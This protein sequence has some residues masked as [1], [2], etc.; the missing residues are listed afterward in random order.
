MEDN[1]RDQLH[2][3]CLQLSEG[4]SVRCMNAL[5]SLFK[6]NNERLKPLL[7]GKT[8]AMNIPKCGKK[9]A[10]EVE[11]VMSELRPF[12][13]Q[14]IST[15]IDELLL[16]ENNAAAPTAEST[17]SP[18]ATMYADVDEETDKLIQHL[19]SDMVRKELDVRLRHIVN[20]NIP[21]YRD[22]EQFL[23][24]P[25]LIRTWNGTG[26]HSADAI[27]RF[28]GRF[29]AHFR[30]MLSSD[31]LDLR[32]QMVALD[33]PFLNAEECS[34]AAQY[35][36]DHG[37]Y[38]Q[39]F[40]AHRYFLTTSNKKSRIYAL[41]NGII[42]SHPSLE[43]IARKFGMSRERIRQI[44]LMP[45]TSD[46]NGKN[47]WLP[48]HWQSYDFMRQ[49]LL[50]ADTISWQTLQR[51]E[52]LE[53]LEPYALFF[54]LR[55]VVPLSVVALKTDG[56]RANSRRAENDR[57]KR[58]DLLFAYAT[59]YNFFPFEKA[60]ARV[61]HRANLQKITEQRTSLSQLADSYFKDKPTP[62]HHTTIIDM[63]SKILPMMQHVEVEGDDIVFTVN[64]TNYCEEIYQILRAEGKAM[65]VDHIY[66]E[67]RLRLPDDHHTN[68][69]FIR[70]YLLHDKRFE[71][72]GSKSTYQLR[73]WNRFAGTIADLAVMLLGSENQ[74]LTVEELRNKIM[75]ERPNTTPDSCYTTVYL[76]VC[77]RRLDYYVDNESNKTATEHN[78]DGKWN[79]YYVGL[80][81]KQYDS[82][83]WLSPHMVQGAVASV[84]RFISENHRLP[85][86]R[87]S[88]PLEK[89][90]AG[91]LRRY[92]LRMN[93][94]DKEQAYWDSHM[95][96]IDYASYPHNDRELTFAEHCRQM[97]QWLN[98]GN[99]VENGHC[100]S[101][102][103]HWYKTAL[104]RKERMSDFE[105]RMFEW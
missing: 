15:S 49:P 29:H 80:A 87:G 54:I 100:P 19:Y 39:I 83:Y 20:Q 70:S 2:W 31:E 52:H 86:L 34:F 43:A 78:T 32:R 25:A 5:N 76:A 91:V 1:I 23:N 90:L 105:K 50:T 67:F 21:H 59:E 77:D 38:P 33:Y 73:E 51:E 11:E 55:Q 69:N 62:E 71:A 8:T 61:A 88:N 13:E 81:G 26:R 103:H 4:K 7:L 45:V 16:R 94:T 89:Q 82:R 10:A 44:S 85:F 102:L 72:V 75:A 98:K 46:L 30:Q 28:I 68:S 36:L 35:H 14:L 93:T 99:S 101:K 79:R 6:E 24:N 17:D 65:T 42:A 48:E 41:A 56:A 3:K 40:I 9:T 27:A 60:I 104:T 92:R 74:P 64:H 37:H 22:S 53:T 12:Y 18:H 63:L 97:K 58:P 47:V 66:E 96:D 57:W 95:A 84:R